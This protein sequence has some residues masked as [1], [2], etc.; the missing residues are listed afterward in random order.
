MSIAMLQMSV[1]VG[2]RH[3]PPVR[4]LVQAAGYWLH[5]A[6]CGRSRA[7]PAVHWS[8]P[9]RRS[10]SSLAEGATLAAPALTFRVCKD[11]V[12]VP[13]HS[14]GDVFAVLLDEDIL[15]RTGYAGL[16]GEV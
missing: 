13:H 7:P 8:G 16:L 14:L 6:S 1:E 3:R 5:G 9:W 15:H 4:V 2:I 11:R 12:D 10:V